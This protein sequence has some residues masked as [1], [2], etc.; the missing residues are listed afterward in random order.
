MRAPFSHLFRNPLFYADFMLNLAHFG[1]PFAT[2]WLTFGSLWA[3]FW[4]SL[5]A[6]S[7]TFAVGNLLI[8]IYIIISFFS[9]SLFI[10]FGPCPIYV[11]KSSFWAP[12]GII[13]I[14]MIVMITGGNYNYNFASDGNYNLNVAS[15]GNYNYNCAS[16]G[17]YKCKSDRIQNL[18]KKKPC[19]TT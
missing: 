7:G 18:Q 16:D 17:N 10:E 5:E 9:V 8:D 4:C 2:L 13:I 19:G 14:I 15:D 11:Q 1:L 3:P 12:A 6:R